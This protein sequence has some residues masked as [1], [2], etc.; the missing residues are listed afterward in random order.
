MAMGWAAMANPPSATKSATSNSSDKKAAAKTSQSTQE[1]WTQKAARGEEIFVHMKTSMG[2]IVLKLFSKD[3]P[4]TVQN[5]VGLATGEKKWTNPTTG[6]EESKPLYPGTL[7]HRVIPE[8]MIQGGDP[9]GTGMGGP[10][11]FFEDEFQS[12][13]KFNRPG[14]LG[15]AKR[16]QPDT[17]GSQFFITVAPKP[18]LDGKYTLFGE[19]VKGFDVVQKIANVP[20]NPAD[21]PDQDIRIVEIKLSQTANPP[22]K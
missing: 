2:D 10:G 9:L 19:V 1:T 6:K 4:K 20:R 18:H 14:L 15:M 22:A 13:S 17:N 21:R 5:F 3:A 11:Y 7:F 8:F 16:P 12:G